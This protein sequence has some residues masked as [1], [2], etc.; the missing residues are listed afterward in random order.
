MKNAMFVLAAGVAALMAGS[1]SAQQLNHPPQQQGTQTQRPSQQQGPQTQRRAITNRGGDRGNRLRRSSDQFNRLGK[2]DQRLVEAIEDADSPSK[3]RRYMQQA[4]NSRSVEVRTAMVNALEYADRHSATDFAYFIGDPSDEVA[5]A[6][7]S[8]WTSALEE[9][10]GE[11][12]VRAILETAEILRSTSGG[13]RQM[14][15]QGFH[16]RQ[17]H[18][19]V[20]QRS[21]R[22]GQRQDM[23]PGMRPN[24]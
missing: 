15:G 24:R 21:G 10:R 13:R 8:A 2:D 3:L 16:S 9:V 7:L 5:D 20:M 6:A 4:M 23:M 19:P 1:A 11:G 14:S 22:E 17:E 12:R 18:G